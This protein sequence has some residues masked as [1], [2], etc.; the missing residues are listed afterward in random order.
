MNINETKFKRNR[1]DAIWFIFGTMVL[2]VGNT[3]R[4][5]LLFRVVQIVLIT[6]HSNDGADRVYSLV[7]KGK[8]IVTERNPLRVTDQLPA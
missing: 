5:G 1:M 7:N 3:K 2:S 6:L 4:F 8:F